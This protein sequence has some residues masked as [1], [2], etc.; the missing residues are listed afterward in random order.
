M[1]HGNID[2][3]K[4]LKELDV[5]Q[6][7]DGSDGRPAPTCTDMNFRQEKDYYRK[8]IKDYKYDDAGRVIDL[9]CGYARWSIFLAE[10]NDYVLGV[11]SLPDLV[12]ISKNMAEYLEFDNL[13]FK[14][15]T[16]SA[17]PAEDNTF[18]AAWIHGVIFLVD[19]G[20]ALKEAARVLKPG[21]RLFVGAGNGPGKMLQKLC[22]GYEQEGWDHRLCKIGVQA[23][24]QGPLADG[25]PNY[26][27][28]A[29]LDEIYGKYGFTIE[30]EYPVL[31][32]SI[33][34]LSSKDAK[35]FADTYKF[36]D[37]FREESKFR[38]DILARYKDLMRQLEFD[39]WFSARLEK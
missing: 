31:D 28:K 10:V 29:T 37:R 38:D 35:L 4:N 6:F 32:Y 12:Q 21:G 20:A 39:L 34:G 23:F 22:S 2:K 24:E 14:V 13:E 33:G 27:T 36:I 26:C 7:F 16:T 8:L 30:R 1:K 25:P 5:K 18:D 19:R 3:I 17:V 11:D 9:G 15:G